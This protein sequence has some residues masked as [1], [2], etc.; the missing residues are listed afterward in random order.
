M[1]GAL[2]ITQTAGYGVLYYAFSVF[3]TPMSRELDAEVAELTGAITL[4][5]LISGVAAP[6]IGRWL[7]RH[8]GRGL[9]TAGSALGALAVLAWSQVQSV[10]QLYL[11]CVVLGVASA[12]VLYEAAFAVIVAW[13]DAARRGP[14]LLAVTV[15]AG[16]ASSIFLPLTG[17]LVDLYG[18]RPTLVIL[19]IGYAAVCVPLHLFAVRSR[20]APPQVDRREIVGAALRERPFW[21]LAAVRPGPGGQAGLRQAASADPS[22]SGRRHQPTYPIDERIIQIP[23]KHPV[24]HRGP[25]TGKDPHPSR[26]PLRITEAQMEHLSSPTTDFAAG[27]PAGS[28]C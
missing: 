19:A 21:L 24:V 18:W 13:F 1:I 28:A 9:M 17:L 23:H 7:D 14:A 4:A 16:F 25:A 6:A 8:G 22:T 2:A 26:R 11:V 20:G 5:V 27:V 10:A 15:V 3:I 12:M